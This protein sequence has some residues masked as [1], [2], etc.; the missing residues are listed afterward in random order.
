[1]KSP[2]RRK[3]KVKSK[4]R[5][6]TVRNLEASCNDLMTMV[7]QNHSMFKQVLQQKIIVEEINKAKQLLKV[8]EAHKITKAH[9]FATSPR[10]DALDMTVKY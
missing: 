6:K 3:I 5:G 4:R 9:T 10:F 1:M 8:D 2:P 7:T